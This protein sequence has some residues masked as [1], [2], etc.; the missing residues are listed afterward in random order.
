MRQT[1]RPIRQAQ[2]LTFHDKT[3]YF[4][5]QRV[6]FAALCLSHVV[7]HRSN[8]L[9]N[10]AK[11]M[12][13]NIFQAYWGVNFYNYLCQDFAILHFCDL[14]TIEINKLNLYQMKRNIYKSLIVILAL[15]SHISLCAQTTPKHEHR[16][17]WVTTAWRMCWPQSYGTGTSVANAQKAEADAI[18]DLMQENGFNAVY[19]QVRGMSDAMYKSSYEP[20]SSYVSGSRGTAPSY[21]PLEYWVNACH[22]RGMACYAWVNPYRYESS[23]GTWG[24]ADYRKNNPSWLLAYNSAVILNPG[25]AEVRQRIVDVCR[26]IVQNYDIDGMV[27]D[28]YFYLNSIPNSYD[29]SLYNASGSSL[30]QADWRR[31]N[32][33]TMVREVYNMIQSVK[34]YVRFGISPAGVAKESASKY[35]ISTTSISSASDWQYSQIYSDPLAW[36]GEGTVDFISPQLYWITSHSTNGYAKLSKW[37]SDACANYFNRHFYSS[38]SISFLYSAN[39]T[40]NWAEVATQIQLNR[41]YTGNNAPGC[42]LFGS[43]D[44]TGVRTEGLAPYLKTNKFQNLALQPAITWKNATNPGPVSNLALSGSTLSWTGY[45]NMRYA[46]YAVPSG[47]TPGTDVSSQYLIGNPYEATFDVS[48]YTSGYQLGVSVVDRYGNEYDVTW[49]GSSSVVEQLPQVTITDPKDGSTTEET[50]SFNWTAIEGATYTLE[51]STSS[52]FSSI[53]FSKSTT[54]TTL[55]S[56]AFNLAQG[57]TYYWRVKASKSGYASSTSWV[58]SFTTYK[59]QSS[60]GS[61]TTTPKDPSSYSAVDNFTIENLW[62]YSVNTNNFPSTLGGDQRSMTAYNGNVYVT[63]RDG[64]L[65]EFSGTTGEY[66][67]SITLSGDYSTSSSGTALTYK[68]NDVFVDGAGNLCISNMTINTSTQPLTVCTVNLSTGATTR[69][70]ESSLSTSLRIDYAAARGDVTAQGGEIWAAVANTNTIY[71]WTRNAYGSWVANG[72]TIGSY[73]SN[74]INA[75]TNNSTAPRVLPLSST[76]FVLDGHNSAPSLYTFVTSGTATLNDSFANNTSLAPSA[77]NWNGLCTATVNNKPI[78]A[79]VSSIAP[80][81]FFIVNNPSNFNYSQMSKL[82]QVPDAGFGSEANSY[83]SAQPAAINNSDGT[84]T[85]FLYTPNNGIAAY[86]VSYDSGSSSETPV[87]DLSAVTLTSPT[88]GATTTSGF[89]F[90]WSAISGATYTI[91]VSTS[92]TFNSIDF[93]ATT[94]TNSYSSSNFALA[95]GTTYYWRVKA[96]KDGYNSSV[97]STASFKTATPD[98]SPVTLTS[99]ASGATTTDGF[100]FSWSSI[101][102][103][104]YTLEI[105]TSSAFSNIMFSATTTAVS[106]SSNNFDLDSNTTYYWRVKAEVSG[107]NSSTSEVRYFTTAKPTLSAVTLNSPI[108]GVTVGDSFNF[109]WSA[110]SGA[111]YTLEISP[112]ATFATIMF[113]SQTSATSVASSNFDFTENTKYYWRVVAEK[114]GYNSSTSTIESFMTPKTEVINPEPPV[115]GLPTDGGEYAEKQGL[116]IENLWIYSIKTSNYPGEHLGR[117]QRGMAAYKG[118]LYICERNNSSGYLLEF[119]G[120]TGEYSRTISL[121]GDYLTLSDGSTLGYPCNDVFVDGG[122]NLCVSNMVTSFHSSG[123]INICIVDIETGATTRVMESYFSDRSMRV[124]HCMV[125][126]DITKSGAKVFAATSAGSGSSQYRNRIYCWTRNA[127]H[128]TNNAYTYWTTNTN[129]RVRSFYPSSATGFG[130]APRVLPIASNQ[131]IVDGSTSYPTLYSFS[132][133]SASILDSFGSNSSIKP[134]GMLSAGMC[135]AQVNGKPLYIYAFND[136]IADFFNFAVVYNPENFDYGAMELLWTIPHEGIGNVTHGYVSAIPAVIENDDQS[137]TLFIYVPNNGIA[138]Y[139]IYDPTVTAIEEVESGNGLEIKVSGKNVYFTEKADVVTVYN[140]AGA[141]VATGENIRSMNLNH[142]ST[143]VYVVSANNANGSATQ[144][145]IIK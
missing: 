19:F 125:Y 22:S 98:L 108:G 5:Y 9:C 43:R 25:M 82:W 107:Y 17:A 32:V 41:D 110:I 18:L 101:V 115:T 48:G 87:E 97:S 136:D 45:D 33:N 38:H 93:S 13:Y 4:Q 119:N 132:G 133:T 64:Y 8:S 129:A 137:I 73:Y 55:S 126:G 92:V 131:L 104:T 135:T 122:G 121:T 106:Y 65:Y 27:F 28:D 94:T 124:D 77:D 144:R 130:N 75:A 83:V 96:E 114:S 113:S 16:A 3:D 35:G 76:Q 86:K 70:F 91:E 62:M 34:P 63:H 117:D 6:A 103:A 72:T 79:Y 138:A 14:Y 85:I 58:G 10:R 116:I 80:N 52:A 102:G 21:D 23:E 56:T 142:L 68:C 12:F 145:V 46:I 30:S 11:Y 31:E 59:S 60:G 89:S 67:R 40:A 78:F 74:T 26:E 7:L 141:I 66:L 99:P 120:K 84:A 24:T 50:F 49:L 61:T 111:T 42:V 128:G 54:A 90:N 112:L 100:S 69:V 1:L 134:A 53:A 81:A 118:N 57:T 15:I 51:I 2:P 39:T 109:S 37:W 44:F 139:R 71:R 127:D 20:W 88:N 123:Q 143:G 140:P 105:A 36:L 29:S 95:Q 47:V